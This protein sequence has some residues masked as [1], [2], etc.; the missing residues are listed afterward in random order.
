MKSAGNF[1]AW[2]SSLIWLGYP[3]NPYGTHPDS[4][5]QSN[6]SSILFNK[7]FPCFDGI[8]M[9]SMKCLWMSVIPVFPESSSNSFTDPTTTISSP[10]SLIQIGIGFPHYLFLEKHQ[11]LASSNQLWN[12]CSWIFF[13]THLV[14]ILLAKRSSLT[15][16]TLIN[17][18]AC[19]FYINGV[20]LL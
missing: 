11:S 9:S 12:L 16:S 10:S 14:F 20:S 7:P 17:H 1:L 3:Y 5:Q 2:S 19:A 13:G 4:N 6:T 18:D 15:L 8:V